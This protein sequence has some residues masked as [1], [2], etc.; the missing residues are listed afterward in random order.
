ME[1]LAAIVLAAGKGTRMNS[2]IP[3]VMHKIA[4]KPMLMHVI[5]N[6]FLCNA[7]KIV[8]VTSPSMQ[9]VRDQV[10]ER[11][12]DMIENVVQQ[13]QLGT[14]DAVKSAISYLDGFN[15]IVVILYGD[16]PLVRPETIGVM[17]SFMTSNPFISL[18]TLG[19][20]V[21]SPNEYGR[22]VLDKKGDIVRIVETRDANSEEKNITLCNSGVMAV[23]SEVLFELIGKIKN[24]N[25][26]SEYYLT[27]LVKI[28]TDEGL[29]CSVVTADARELIGVNSRI[30]LANAENKVQ[31]RL[32]TNAIESGVT[33]LKPSS[34]YMSHDTKPGQD[35]VTHPNVVFGEGVEIGD[36]VEIKAFSEISGS[37]IAEGAVIGPFARIRPGCEIEENAHVGNFVELKKTK[38]GK[39]SKANHLTYLGDCE[40]GE[41]ANIGAGTI[42]CNYDGFN[43]FKTEIGNGAFIGSNSSLVA[44]LKIGDGAIIAAG[45]TITKDV[46]QDA[47]AFAR[48]KQDEKADWAKNFRE[49]QT[50]E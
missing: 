49:K 43:K 8:T 31:I 3:K 12:H 36:N 7:K 5:D 42:T 30:E 37:K 21:N 44:P 1:S 22:I 26:K 29:R 4:G 15:G 13:E 10:G 20:E 25:S 27:D 2:K 47:L 32:R 14:G 39:G 19:M 50:K 6:A 24:D 45:S 9:K 28:A 46:S 33:M 38:L 35:V 41:K 11:Y 34:V 23:R 18:I 48:S 17:T 40:I 16:T